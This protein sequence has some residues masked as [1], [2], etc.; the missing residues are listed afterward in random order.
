VHWLV[1]RFETAARDAFAFLVEQGFTVVSEHDLS[2]PPS[3]V[4]VRFED[5]PATVVE[6]QLTTASDGS[7]AVTTFVRA[8][9]ADH[10]LGPSTAQGDEWVG[11]ELH[12]HAAQVRDV[13]GH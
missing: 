9:E 13:L 12:D 2:S 6:T 1:D 3:H 5:V 7:F 10:L 8:D 11:R 4:T